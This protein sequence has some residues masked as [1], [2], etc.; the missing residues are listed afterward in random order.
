MLLFIATGCYY[1]TIERHELW[2]SKGIIDHD[3][4]DDDDDV[5]M[6]NSKR[7]FR[8]KRSHILWHR[9]VKRIVIAFLMVVVVPWMAYYGTFQRVVDK[10]NVFGKNDPTTVHESPPPPSTT[11]TTT[12]TDTTVLSQRIGQQPYRH[13]SYPNNMASSSHACS[14]FLPNVA[15]AS[16]YPKR[17]FQ[18]GGAGH[19]YLATLEYHQTKN[20]TVTILNHRFLVLNLTTVIIPSN[21]NNNNN[22]Y[23]PCPKQAIYYHIHKNGGTTM[24]R[25]LQLP[26]DNFYSKRERRMGRHAFQQEC[27]Y[28]AQHVYQAQQQQQQSPGFPAFTF[29]RD[30]VPRFLSS[31]AQILKLRQWYQ[32]LYPCYEYNT[33][34]ELLDCVLIKME[35]EHS[36]PEMH[37]NPQSFELYHYIQGYDIQ[38]YVMD[39]VDINT[40]MDI[41]NTPSYQP[42]ISSSSSVLSTSSSSTSLQ[43]KKK[44]ERSTMGSSIRRFPHFRF[45]LDVLTPSLIQRICHF[46]QPDVWMIQQTNITTTLCL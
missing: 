35:T 44:K 46:Y 37:L 28:V 5:L 18:Q 42:S 26:M 39:L 2:K 32:Q 22:Q 21:N 29:V 36:I 41:L 14:T 4:D 6:T 40:V 3:N 12:S 13:D 25:H 11:T 10:K 34:N 16:F 38:V 30:P 17:F 45:T 15:K 9:Y 43:R 27:H 1:S 7:L 19:P 8:Q 20:R 23:R 24:E 33:T 31:V